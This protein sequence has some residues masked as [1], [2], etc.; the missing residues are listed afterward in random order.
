MAKAVTKTTGNSAKFLYSYNSPT[1]RLISHSDPGK[2]TLIQNLM[3]PNCT[4]T[5]KHVP[6]NMLQ[7][8][9]QHLVDSTMAQVVQGALWYKGHWFN[10]G[11]CSLAVKVTLRK[12]QNSTLPPNLHLQCINLLMVIFPPGAGGHQFV[13][14]NRWMQIC[15]ISK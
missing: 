2:W 13:S 9:C 6:A 12:V 4:L 15:K 7:M 3:K 11:P 8:C 5:H 1:L 10:P 14:V